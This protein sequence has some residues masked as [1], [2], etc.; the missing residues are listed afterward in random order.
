MLGMAACDKIEEK[1]YIKEV[2]NVQSGS[3]PKY[4]LL[5]DYTGVR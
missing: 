2:G 5:E 1:D 4:I 3:V